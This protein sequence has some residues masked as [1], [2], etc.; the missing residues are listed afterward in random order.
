M[1]FHVTENVLKCDKINVGEN[2]TLLKSDHVCCVVVVVIQHGLEAG[3]VPQGK[4]L[5]ITINQV[6][7]K[8]VITV[9]IPTIQ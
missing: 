4:Y 5:Q 9:E 2:D 6:R 8:V 1:L 7:L 3:K